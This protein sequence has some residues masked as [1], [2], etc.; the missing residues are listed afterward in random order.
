M[1]AGA[2]PISWVVHAVELQ[3]DWARGETVADVVEIVPGARL[4]KP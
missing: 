1:Q 4:L 3:R 2:T